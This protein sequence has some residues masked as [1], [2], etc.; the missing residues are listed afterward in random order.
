MICKKC[1]TEF[2]GAFCPKC[3]ERAE[4]KLTVCPVCG[5]ERAEGET[6]CSKCGYSYENARASKEKVTRKK[7]DFSKVKKA[8]EDKYWIIPS[9]GRLLLGVLVLLSLIAPV[10][11]HAGVN[12]A[13]NGYV[14]AFGVNVTMTY[15]VCCAALLIAGVYT[16][17]YGAYTL[18][19]AF[20]RRYFDVG[21]KLYYIL[22]GVLCVIV[23]VIGCIGCAGAGDWY[24]DAGAGLSL[25]VFVGI[26]GVALLCI[27]IVYENK[28]FDNELAAQDPL[29]R[30]RDR[31]RE[32]KLNKPYGIAVSAISAAIVIAIV[33]MSTVSVLYKNPFNVT[34]SGFAKTRGDVIRQFGVPDGAEETDTYFTYYSGEYANVDKMIEALQTAQ[35]AASEDM[36]EKTTVTFD[37]LRGTDRKEDIV[38]SYVC[39]V[40]VP[41]DGEQQEERKL[42]KI[43]V[44]DSLYFDENHSANFSY[45]ARYDDG[46][47]SR[48][49]L[50][51]NENSFD[52]EKN[53]YIFS[54]ILGE[55]TVSVDKLDR[56]SLS[57]YGMGVID[58]VLYVSSDVFT[59]N[60]VI[61]ADTK[62]TNSINTTD[63]SKVTTIH[64]LDGVEE[65]LSPEL[66][67]NLTNVTEIITP[68]SLK[69]LTVSSIY[70]TAY[71]KDPSNWEDGYALYMDN[72]LAETKE[73]VKEEYVVRDG[74]TAINQRAFY[75]KTSLKSITIPASVTSIGADAFLG[76]ELTTANIPA[77]AIRSITGDKLKTV[78]INSGTRI[79]DHAFKNCKSL[80]SITIPDSITSIDNSAFVDCRNIIIFCKATSKPDGWDS[81]WNYGNPVIWGC[82]NNN[83]ASDGYIYYTDENIRYALKD[84]NAVVSRYTDTVSD[85]IE[86]PS[87][88]SYKGRDYIV[89]MI[90]E[91]AFAG[92]SSLTS[93]TIPDSV[94]RISPQAF[95]GCSSLTSAI[96]ENSMD[97]KVSILGPSGGTSVPSTGLADPA[98]AAK[99]LTNT[100][101]DYF[102]NCEKT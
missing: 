85:N 27:R 94:E 64:I 29:N 65:I 93:V 73:D 32:K 57:Y 56:V 14:N 15:T 68:S 46:S 34:A 84:G 7:V 22:D 87:S 50:E 79:G 5:K 39:E 69:Y 52:E 101:Y 49:V 75:N 53:A 23:A 9:A 51:L 10:M 48:G 47:F 92:C 77:S 72:F 1:G 81:N 28:W 91:Y 21:K 74:T 100:Y 16:L 63:L 90:D 42:K 97:W 18:I 70:N 44:K 36:D 60:A 59:P 83:V 37:N 25:C 61:V 58:N 24:A 95:S 71:Y 12:T 11:T 82:D 86:I 89:I 2:D 20:M 35:E 17:V 43:D 3:G 66:F 31:A 41:A 80:E 99:L 78:I 88:V 54:D 6:F 96:F 13:G 38:K 4:E 62:N 33:I 30:E 40:V 19:R 67:K 102:W 45:V 8:F 98:T 76:C 26:A 55:Y